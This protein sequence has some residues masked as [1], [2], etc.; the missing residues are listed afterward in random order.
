MNLKDKIR[1]IEDFPEEGIE[2]QDITTLLKDIDAY[3][4]AID[5][6]VERYQDCDIDVIVG[7][8]SRGFLVGAPLALE[9]GISFVPARKEGKLPAE[10]VQ[11]DYDLEYGTSTL[12]LHCDAIDKGDR[13]LIIDDLL[14]TGGTVKA[15][16]ELVEELEGDIVE[17]AFLIELSFLKGRDELTGYDIYSE[18]IE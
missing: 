2:F 1:V 5:Q 3:Q 17:L 6:F 18:I 13:V 14:A 16:A 9:L 12:E 4:Y 15:A 11:A 8:E 10:I 7:I